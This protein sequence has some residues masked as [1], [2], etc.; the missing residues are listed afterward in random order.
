MKKNWPITI[1][2]CILI[3]VGG[4]AALLLPKVVPYDQCSDVYKKYAGMDII[5]ATYIK[6][7][8]VNDSVHVNV[9]LL[10]AKTDSAWTIL[11]TDFNV[12]EIPEEYRELFANS[13]TIDYWYAPK[14]DYLAPT[15]SILTNNDVITV[16][17]NK[18]TVCVFHI[19][20][21]DQVYSIISY[22]IKEITAQ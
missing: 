20:D 11:Q 7:Y 1:L 10:Q 6:D 3:I 19:T 17:R 16:S 9:T 18:Q 12:T 2:V 21:D 5:D 14:T 4:G 22:K 13:N 8:E 15:D